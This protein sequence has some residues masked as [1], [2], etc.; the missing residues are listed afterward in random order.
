MNGLTLWLRRL[1][2]IIYGLVES[3]RRPARP[4]EP[5]SAETAETKETLEVPMLTD[6]STIAPSPG[7]DGRSSD[8]NTRQEAEREVVGD[9]VQ[10]H[11]PVTSDEE[12][13]SEVPHAESDHF[14]EARGIEPANPLVSQ[15]QQTAGESTDMESSPPPSGTQSSVATSQAASTEEQQRRHLPPEERGGRPRGAGPTGLKKSTVVERGKKPELVCWR[16]GMNWVVGLAV[17]EDAADH[18]WFVNQTSS[19]LE[20]DGQKPGHWALADPLGPVEARNERGD[21]LFYFPEERFRIFK[22]FGPSSD[23]GTYMR[24]LTCGRFLIVAPAEWELTAENS[25]I[26]FPIA[27]E[28]LVDMRWRAHHVRL[29][30]GVAGPP[31]TFTTGERASEGVPVA[32]SA[33]DLEGEVLSDACLDAGPLFHGEPPRLRCRPGATYKTAVVGK[34]GPRERCPSWRKSASNFEELRREISRRGSGWF[35][36]RLYDHDDRL[37]ESL[38]FRF[39]SK[40]KSIKI[41]ADS[42]LP[43]PYGH[44]PAI[45][46][47]L[48][49]DTVEVRAME[50]DPSDALSAVRTDIGSRIEIPP[51]PR[52]D[53]TR[54]IIEE[55]HGSGVVICLKVDRVWWALRNEQTEYSE[56]K[57]TDRPL[58]LTQEDLTATSCQILRVRLPSAWRWKEVRVGLEPQRSVKLH[59]VAGSPIEREVASRELGRF[60]DLEE[61]RESLELK[62]WVMSEGSNA[63]DWREALLAQVSLTPPRVTPNPPPSAR[64]EHFDPVPL[65]RLLTA[66]RRR[67]PRYKRRIDELRRDYYCPIRPRRRGTREQR[68]AFVRQALLLMAF[69][70]EE[71]SALGETPWVPARWARRAEIARRQFA[72]DFDEFKLSA[73]RAAAVRSHGQNPPVTK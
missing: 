48:H 11:H 14:E 71:L 36:V 2:S 3:L 39:S 62:L 22:L 65:M 26:E 31:P 28:Y 10:S 43:G 1:L 9:H 12:L 68:Q 21:R 40:L 17:P 61:P 44:N 32:G 54:W 4:G 69:V 5:T 27:P 23:R 35:F 58:A 6:A 41:H 15:G 53:Q 24:S 52:F 8:S 63:S 57:W 60:A 7:H 19:V 13:A 73:S 64:L 55:H 29:S 49:D 45:V 34:E 30:R 59:P 20:E 46:D 42:P 66:I 38:D 25:N 51:S 72:Q 37:I 33:F 56:S 70:I 50:P 67:H 16:Q 47:I 18:E